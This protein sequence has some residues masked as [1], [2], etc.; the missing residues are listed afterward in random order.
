MTG[1]VTG[2]VAFN[3]DAAS[4]Q[5]RTYAGR[6][7]KEGTDDVDVCDAI[8]S[9]ILPLVAGRRTPLLVA[10]DGRSGVGK[11]T[12]AA[13]VAARVGATVVESDDFY[14]G[15][16]D[17]E[18]AQRTA[19]HKAAACI[20]WRRLRVDALDP[21]LA[22]RTAVWR[23]F[24]FATGVGLAAHTVRRAPAAV[25]ILDGVY[26]ARPELSDLVDLAVLVESRD[27]LVRRRRLIA[28]EGTSFMDAWHALWDEAEDHYFTHVRP[29]ASFDLVVTVD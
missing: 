3:T 14:A 21:L 29:R 5:S 6:L 16:T 9:A 28:R 25:I 8:V 19:E 10:V 13:C 12:L 15:G 26:S 1:R 17:A 22:G 4:G 11:S 18:W 7:A 20:D 23:P 24:N 27:D 2:K